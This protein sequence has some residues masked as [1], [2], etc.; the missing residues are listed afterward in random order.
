[1]R[2]WL[3]YLQAAFTVWMLYDC[4]KRRADTLW[5]V[6]TMVPFGAW[7][8]FFAV[9]IHDYDL[10]WL[11]ARITPREPLDALRYRARETPSFDNRLKLAER[12]R[13]DKLFVEAAQVYEQ[14][15]AMRQQNKAVLFGLA[16]CHLA[17]GHDAAAV[18]VLEKLVAL[19]EGYEDHA[20]ATALAEALARLG[21][22]E[23]ALELFRSVARRSSALVH[24]VAY[25]QALVDAGHFEQASGVL[26]KA[27]EAYRYAP[28]YVRRR[29]RRAARNAEALRKKLGGP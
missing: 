24:Q 16:G 27:L 6:I 13:D 5:Y 15:H 21:R 4:V 18:E 12:L 2:N 14:A 1:M 22:D 11:R 28:P 3:Y 7:V 10:R 26:A 9:K 8:Y 29:E 19:D 23:E 20:A 25:A 17:Q